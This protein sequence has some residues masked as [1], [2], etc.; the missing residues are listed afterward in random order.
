MT[1][2]NYDDAIE[3]LCEYNMRIN[4]REIEVSADHIWRRILHSWNKDISD[5]HICEDT[6]YSFFCNDCFVYADVP[7]FFIFLCSKNI[8]V[9]TLSDDRQREHKASRNVE[10][11]SM[12]IAAQSWWTA[13]LWFQHHSS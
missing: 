8:S 2:E 4:P 1:E 13:P 9:A 11:F 7:E 6:F 5:L 12:Q 10:A 3:I